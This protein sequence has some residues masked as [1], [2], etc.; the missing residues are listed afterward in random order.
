MAKRVVFFGGTFDPVHVGHVRIARALGTAVR[1]DRVL[2]TPTGVNPLKPPPVASAEDRLAMLRLAIR[3]DEWLDV[4]ELELHRT[5]PCYTIDTIE[6]LREQLGPETDIYLA[7]GADMPAD[8]PKWRRAGD[9]LNRVRLLAACRPPMKLPDVE[10][11]LA[12]LAETMKA[13]GVQKIHAQAVETPLLDISS[14]DIRKRLREEQDVDDVLEP[15]V[16]E[17]IRQHNLYR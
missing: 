4:C 7:V 12:K 5:P 9:L 2:L 11:A 14:S 6:A 16:L 13:R 3:N 17:Y 15:S 1:A 10:K 8:L